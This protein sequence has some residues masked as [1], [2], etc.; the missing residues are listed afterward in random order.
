MAARCTGKRA[1]GKV[2]S[3]RTWGRTHAWRHVP[4]DLCAGSSV[5]LEVPRVRI[6]VRAATGVTGRRVV[7]WLVAAG[8]SITAVVHNPQKRAALARIGA[9]T[10]NV[11]LLA[12]DALR[13]AVLGH[14]VVISLATHMPSS[15]LHML[16]PGAWRENDRL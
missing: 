16:L 4:G 1:A 15:S 7:P 11:D 8:H 14:E 13:T 12:R 3:A 2:R 6:F 5:A 10:V 9:R